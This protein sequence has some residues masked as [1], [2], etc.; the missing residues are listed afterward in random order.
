MARDLFGTLATQVQSSCACLQVV[1]VLAQEEARHRGLLFLEG[2]RL[3]GNMLL[4]V[5]RP[6]V[7]FEFLA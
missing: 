6:Q 3:G 4:Q 5:P 1:S 2:H 7:S